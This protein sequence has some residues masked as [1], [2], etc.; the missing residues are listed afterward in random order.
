M[1]R[2]QTLLAVSV[3]MTICAAVSFDSHEI[4]KDSI[5]VLLGG[6]TDAVFLLST[7][8]AISVAELS[9]PLTVYAPD[10]GSPA[11][12]FNMVSEELASVPVMRARPPPAKVQKSIIKRIV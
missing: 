7:Q 1:K 4:K 2:F 12:N 11:S 9:E 6:D 3:F 8:N 10:L 5:Q